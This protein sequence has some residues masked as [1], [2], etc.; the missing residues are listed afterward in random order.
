MVRLVPSPVPKQTSP[1]ASPSSCPS[2]CPSPCGEISDW[3]EFRSSQHESRRGSCR[4]DLGEISEWT[5]FR[6]SPSPEDA[7]KEGGKDNIEGFRRLTTVLDE[8]ELQQSFG[9]S[10][11]LLSYTDDE[12]YMHN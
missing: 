4:S 11:G 3:T 7:H 5:E 6:S 9:R 10:S 8:F 12:G 1:L 2:P